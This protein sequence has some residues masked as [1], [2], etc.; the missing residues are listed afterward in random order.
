MWVDSNWGGVLGTG[1]AASLFVYAVRHPD[2]IVDA[3]PRAMASWREQRARADNAAVLR[4]EARINRKRF[5]LRARAFLAQLDAVPSE[6][7]LSGEGAAQLEIFQPETIRPEE[8][9]EGQ[10]NAPGDES[11]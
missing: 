11:A 6:S 7:V 3:I 8:T 10:L 4:L 9:E 5:E 1:A 2:R